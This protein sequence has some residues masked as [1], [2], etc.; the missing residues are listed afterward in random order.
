MSDSSAANVNEGEHEHN[1]FKN[2]INE[3][4]ISRTWVCTRLTFDTPAVSSSFLYRTLY[5]VFKS[6]SFLKK[7]KRSDL[8]SYVA[9]NAAIRA[10]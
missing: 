10:T 5:A 7:I 1:K 8:M 6:V 4:V 2:A 3:H 9:G